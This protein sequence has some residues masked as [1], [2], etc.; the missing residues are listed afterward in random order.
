MNK[1]IRIWTAQMG[2][3]HAAAKCGLPVLDIT[4]MTGNQHFAPHFFR[5]K[6][7]KAG[8][9]SNGLY[10]DLYI[11]KMKLSQQDNPEAWEEFKKYDEVVVLCYCPKDAFCHRHVF[12]DV[13]GEYLKENGIELINMGEFVDAESLK[14]KEEEKII[15]VTYPINFE[16]LA[17]MSVKEKVALYLVTSYCYY[18]L[19]ESLISDHL[20]DRTCVF[21]KIAWELNLIPEE[22]KK[23]LDLESLEAGTAFNKRKEDY[24][25]WV[26]K[27]AEEMTKGR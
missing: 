23:Y 3:R 20:Y 8:R 2:K 5:V 26:K 24:P 14:K 22:D 21:L 25:E 19:Y 1:A 15:K 7:Y 18:I 6:E 10:T 4:A 17:K 13:M 11:E 16:E 9:I 27:E 12:V